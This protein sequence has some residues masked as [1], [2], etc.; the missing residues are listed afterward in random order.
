MQALEN[1]KIF[2][3]WSDLKHELGVSEGSSEDT[4]LL[5][6]SEVLTKKYEGRQIV[7]LLDEII[8]KAALSKLGEQSFPESAGVSKSSKNGSFY[9]AHI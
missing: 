9:K 6:M 4:E 2:K 3:K 1:N 5:R 7:L 8:V